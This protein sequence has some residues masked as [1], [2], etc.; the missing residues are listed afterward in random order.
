M[1]NERTKHVA[2]G[3]FFV[4]EKVEDGTVTVVRC[5]TKDMV[6]DIL[7]KALPRE[8]FERF[9]T[10]LLTGVLTTLE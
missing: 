8:A 1:V 4:R 6:V 2:I 9:R 3:Y 5:D 10:A 7:T